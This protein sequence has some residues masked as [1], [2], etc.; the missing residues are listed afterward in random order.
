MIRP[1]SQPSCYAISWVEGASHAS[2]EGTCNDQVHTPEKPDKSVMVESENVGEHDNG[3]D[4]KMKTD[5]T[6][7]I[8]SP[9]EGERRPGSPNA[10]AGGEDKEGSSEKNVIR[11]Q[12]VF[13]MF[14]GYSL[15]KTVL[16]RAEVRGD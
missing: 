1:S 16:D 2:G 11:H 7:L 13:E 3:S 8:A 5:K 15:S 4:T 9:G 12:L 14:P 10:T 6:G